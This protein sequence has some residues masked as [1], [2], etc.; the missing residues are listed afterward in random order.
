MSKA[1]KA[2]KGKSNLVALDVN[3][4]APSEDESAASSPAR[5]RKN[6]SVRHV[7][8]IREDSARY[9]T[10]SGP[11]PRPLRRCEEP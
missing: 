9:S 11:W 7:F 6:Q 10:R 3:L 1:K 4:S 5:F 8:P 2:K